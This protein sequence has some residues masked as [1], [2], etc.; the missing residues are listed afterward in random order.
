M[1]WTDPNLVN[2]DVGDPITSADMKAYVRDNLLELKDPPSAEYTLNETSD[3]TTTSTT[4]VDVDSTN[5]ALTINTNGGDVL[6]VFN[7]SFKCSQSMKIS[8]DIEVDGTRHAG[9]DGLIQHGVYNSAAASQPSISFVYLIKDLEAGSH[10]FKLQWK[11]NTG[12]GTLY[13]GAGTSGED[14]H[15][16]FW[17]REVS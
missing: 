4:F 13:A 14:L 5:L 11:V 10:T 15:P 1:T 8:L 16:Q 7:G 17:V 9:D 2:W 6:V 3:Y 12:T